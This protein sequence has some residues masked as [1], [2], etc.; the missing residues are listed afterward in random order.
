MTT[1][2]GGGP[3]HRRAVLQAEAVAGSQGVSVWSSWCERVSRRRSASVSSAAH[4]Y[5]AHAGAGGMHDQR[6]KSCTAFQRA[7]AQ[8]RCCTRE[9]GIRVSSCHIR[10]RRRPRPCASSRQRVRTRRRWLSHAPHAAPA[11][12]P[13]AATHAPPGRSKNHH[14]AA[15]G[16]PAQTGRRKRLQCR[17]PRG[18]ARQR[19]PRVGGRSGQEMSVTRAPSGGRASGGGGSR[20][21]QTVAGRLRYWAA[22]I[23]ASTS[24]RCPARSALVRR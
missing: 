17:Q 22:R 5:R 18:A 4:G 7:P 6:G 12:S 19:L 15:S 1:G 14:A 16:R 10:S 21:A 24:S 20:T 11:S 9:M 8:V 13:R 3:R 2:A 23:S